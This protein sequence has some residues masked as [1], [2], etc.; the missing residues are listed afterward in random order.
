VDIVADVENSL[1]HR[2]TRAG[3]L[4]GV[5]L[6]ISQLLLD[7]KAEGRVGTLRDKSYLMFGEIWIDY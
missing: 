1:L 5:H 3:S 4:N 7:I 6:I 2:E